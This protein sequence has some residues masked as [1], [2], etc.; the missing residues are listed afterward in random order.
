[1]K[2]SLISKKWLPIRLLSFLPIALILFFLGGTTYFFAVFHPFVH[3]DVVFIQTNPRIAE[4]NLK[5]I[6]FTT[7]AGHSD[8]ALINDYY[9][10]LLEVFYRLQYQIFRLNPHGYHL[11]NILVHILNSVMVFHIISFMGKRKRDMES[12]T[13]NSSEDF[14]NQDTLSTALTSSGVLGS[15]AG[16]GLALGV[17]VLFL[18]HPVQ[19]EAVACISGISNLLFAFL[20]LLSFY[21]YLLTKEN[22]ADLR[23]RRALYLYG[24]SLMS[25]L[26]ALG[27][28]EQAV[29]LPVLIALYEVCFPASHREKW[30]RP[31]LQWAGYGVV[32]AGYFIF[33]KTMVG[34]NPGS[35]LNFN[36]EFW[37]RIESI[38]RT[39][40]MYG[41]LIFSPR[42]LHY[43]RSTDILQPF[44]GPLVGLLGVLTL[45]AMIIFYVPV[46]CR[47]VLIFSMGWFLISL[48]P[49]L[50]ILP[51]INEYSYILTAEH[52][53]YLPMI[54]IVLFVLTVGQYGLKRMRP[55]IGSWV[56]PAVL[57]VISF[58]FMTST[59]EQNTYW[60]GEIPLF[61]RTLRFEKLGRVHIL[62]GKAYYF[63][64][65][66]DKAIEELEKAL[67]IIQGYIAKVKDERVL[68]YYRG[69]VKGVY[70]DLAHCY[71]GLGARTQSLNQYLKASA[72]DPN[73][74]VL[75]NNI[76]VNYLLLKEIDKAM[77]HFQKAVSLDSND[78]MAMNNLALCYLERKEEDKA[79]Q[80]LREILKKKPQDLSAR[81]NLERLLSRKQTIEKNP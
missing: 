80:I 66:L 21:L 18:V 26:L 5:T 38:P 63:N 27:A 8:T 30:G 31:L 69:L 79:E 77:E 46:T 11:M 32:L 34:F 81:K 57:G 75:Q 67:H 52:F 50:N 6:F 35:F 44:A 33:R 70:F 10:P 68:N 1:M 61:E 39:L 20:C 60:R 72:I 3:D 40:L 28:K 43:Y 14:L 22:M 13:G 73:D 23:S 24:G 47:R 7:V 45:I 4:F 54:G 29:V 56:G 51:L 16:N 64:G 42:D 74:G 25:F 58:M 59:I 78:L 36:D 76:G 53:L 9:R 48:L 71:E 41:S 37:L 2:D 19:S 15:F 17:A 65:Q 49:T 62:L 12:L 55:K